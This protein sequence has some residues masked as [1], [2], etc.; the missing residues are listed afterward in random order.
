[1][2]IGYLGSRSKR[3]ER[4]FDANEVVPGPGNVQTRRPY[5]ST[6]VQEIGNVAEA[7]DNRWA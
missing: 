4:M 7:S 5:P 1:M 2:E 6:K 3:L